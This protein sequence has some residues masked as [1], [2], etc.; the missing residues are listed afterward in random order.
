[1][2]N[3]LTQPPAMISPQCGTTPSVDDNL[4]RIKSLTYGHRHSCAL[5]AMMLSAGKTVALFCCDSLTLNSGS[6]NDF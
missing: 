2:T 1:L 4:S 6:S 3:R 5:S